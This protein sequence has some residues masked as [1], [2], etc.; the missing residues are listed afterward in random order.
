MSKRFKDLWRSSR[1]VNICQYDFRAIGEDWTPIQRQLFVQFASSLL[2]DE[3]GEID[4]FRLNMSG[5]DTNFGDFVDRGLQLRPLF[6][7]IAAQFIKP[8]LKLGSANCTSRLTAIRL[9]GVLLTKE[10]EH[11][12]MANC[13]VLVELTIEGCKCLFK[14]INSSSLKIFAAIANPRTKFS[15]SFNLLIIAPCLQ[16]L[17]LVLPCDQLCNHMVD[18]NDDK[19]LRSL[20]R[21]RIELLMEKDTNITASAQEIEAKAT[22]IKSIKSLT[23]KL[24]SVT[25]L[26]L[27]RFSNS[28]RGHVFWF[29]LSIALATN[30]TEHI[31]IV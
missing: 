25:H 24:V 7:D 28:V 1:V 27:C 5:G 16:S 9:F 14:S 6:I 2:D 8:V 13:P 30:V 31:S 17:W 12:L 10:F 11:H 18:I 3:S 23:S 29:L 15:S 26:T 22:F 21:V 19:T 20:A 4:T